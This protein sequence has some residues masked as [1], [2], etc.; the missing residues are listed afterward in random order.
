M[1]CDWKYV[2]TVKSKREFNTLIFIRVLKSMVNCILWYLDFKSKRS[3]LC[4]FTT[5]SK[6]IKQQ[7]L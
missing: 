1:K 4:F 6:E 5:N 2:P 7:T 3:K